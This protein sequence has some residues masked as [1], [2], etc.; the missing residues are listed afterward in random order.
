MLHNLSGG[1]GSGLGTLIL[2][3]IKDS[4]PES[5]ITSIPTI[6]S[7]KF[8]CIVEPYN[9]I[10]S[11]AKLMDYSDLCLCIDFESLYDRCFKLMKWMNP[12]KKELADISSIVVD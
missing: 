6:P 7:P 5:N 10:L 12:Y 11:I 4:Y 2:E 8:D 1:T 3:W 9:G